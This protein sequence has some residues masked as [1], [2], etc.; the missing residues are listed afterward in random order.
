M[1]KKI[2]LKIIYG[3][4]DSDSFVKYLRRKGVTIGSGTHFYSPQKISIDV[5]RPYAIT[6]GKNV[7]ITKGVKILTHGFDW[8]VLKGV[9]NDVLGSFGTVNIG[10]NVFIGTD[11]LVLK[12]VNIGNNV[13]IGARSVVTKNLSDNGVYAGNPAKFICTIDEYYKKRIECQLQEAKSLVLAYRKAF[14]KNPP[15]EELSEFFFL[16]ENR[17]NKLNERFI[18]QMKNNGNFELCELL[19]LSGHRRMFDSYEMFLQYCENE[20]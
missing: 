4:N 3:Y 5:T 15:K 13:I 12:G 16:F 20:C 7:H 8:A 19:F 1:L 11:V 10:N 18:Y 2:L 6:I 14:G 17:K 9:Y